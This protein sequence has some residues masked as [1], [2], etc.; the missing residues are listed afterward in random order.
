M[1]STD[2]LDTMLGTTLRWYKVEVTANQAD[3]YK[4]TL[5][6]SDGAWVIGIGPAPDAAVLGALR[7][8]ASTPAIASAITVLTP[9]VGRV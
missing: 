2:L 5:A 6:P 3:P 7:A 4:V 9:L 8:W 1:I